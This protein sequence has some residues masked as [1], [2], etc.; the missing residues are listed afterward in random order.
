MSSFPGA[1]Y[2]SYVNEDG[3]LIVGDEA[4]TEREWRARSGGVTLGRVQIGRPV[5]YDDE[6]HRKDREKRRRL[7]ARRRAA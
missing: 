7:R 2:G 3:W 5:Q 1:P 4:W 6:A